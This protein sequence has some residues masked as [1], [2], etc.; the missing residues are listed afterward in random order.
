MTSNEQQRREAQVDRDTQRRQARDLVRG[1]ADTVLQDILEGRHWRVETPALKAAAHLELINRYPCA[2]CGAKAG[3]WCRPDYGCKPTDRRAPE[4][5]EQRAGRLGVDLA[6]SVRTG[7]PLYDVAFVALMLDELEALPEDERALAV[8]AVNDGSAVED[9]ESYRGR[10]RC[11]RCGRVV[12]QH[13]SGRCDSCESQDAFEAVSESTPAEPAERV[14]TDDDRRIVRAQLDASDPDTLTPPTHDCRWYVLE[15]GW[16]VPVVEVEGERH[17]VETFIGDQW[18]HAETFG[19]GREE[20]YACD[21]DAA[22]DAWFA[23]GEARLSP[24]RTVAGGVELDPAD[25]AFVAENLDYLAGVDEGEH[26][27]RERL[28]EV[29]RRLGL[30]RE[31]WQPA[32]QVRPE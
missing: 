17:A 11:A 25:A 4:N 20:L 30:E 1:A 12:E 23:E 15:H 5:V 29:A 13:E 14:L 2:D 26:T 21:P 28:L 16:F 27:D 6:V 8:L 10:M 19:Y 31:P 9:R 7:E 32:R 3:E 18:G 24:R 22:V